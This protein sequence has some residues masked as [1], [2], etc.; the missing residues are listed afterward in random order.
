MDAAGYTYEEINEPY[1]FETDHVALKENSDYRQ[2]LHTIALLEAQRQQAAK[3]ID[4]LYK[5]QNYALE[6]PLLFA[7]N[8]QKGVHLALPKPQKIAEL[9]DIQ[10]EKYSLNTNFSAFG[11]SS[12]HMTRNKKTSSEGHGN[13]AK[14]KNDTDFFHSSNTAETLV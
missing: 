14:S 10:W 4:V 1:Y 8:L 6:N 3:D 9:P 13:F 12:Q 5:A 2:L 11:S 7:E